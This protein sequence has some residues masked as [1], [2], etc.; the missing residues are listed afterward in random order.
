[1]IV[2]VYTRI[3]RKQVIERIMITPYKQKRGLRE[4]SVGEITTTVLTLGSTKQ[5]SSDIISR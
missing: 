4:D 5:D 2:F 3:I 1:M